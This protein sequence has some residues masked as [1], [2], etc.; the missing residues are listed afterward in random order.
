MRTSYL[1]DISNMNLSKQQRGLVNDKKTYS[2]PLVYSYTQYFCPLQDVQN[3][4]Y[5]VYRIVQSYWRDH[6]FEC[7][8]YGG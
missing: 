7:V 1:A 6:P 3:F 8:L 4:Y 2:S 5:R